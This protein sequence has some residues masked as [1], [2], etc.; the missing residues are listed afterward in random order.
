MDETGLHDDP[1]ATRALQSSPKAIAAN[2]A[3]MTEW[4]AYNLVKVETLVGEP[5]V[6]RSVRGYITV[7]PA[8]SQATPAEMVG[9]LGLRAGVDLVTGAAIYQLQAVPTE[10]GF[11]VRGYT[12]L[13]DGLRLKPGVTED[14]HGYAPGHGAWQVRLT[15][16]VPARLFAVVHPGKRFEPPLHPRVAALYGR[17]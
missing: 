12:T 10:T 9:I 6:D 16:A 14:A 15:S 17:A 8:I 11:E 7:L 1:D 3:R 4:G 5:A 13:P 2:H